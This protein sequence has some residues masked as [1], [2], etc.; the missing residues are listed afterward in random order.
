[1]RDDDDQRR[2]RDDANGSVHRDRH[3]SGL[4][5]DL[6]AHAVRSE[7]CRQPCTSTM[8]SNF[9]YT[10]GSLIRL[11]NGAPLPRLERQTAQ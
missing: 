5:A 2:R 4:I 9:S 11:A 3:V 8:L 7:T 10:S 1:M 6:R